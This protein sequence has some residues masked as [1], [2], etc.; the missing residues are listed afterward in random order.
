MNAKLSE[1]VEKFYCYQFLSCSIGISKP[2]G[3]YPFLF[4][5]YMKYLVLRSFRIFYSG[6]REDTIF[7]N[8]IILLPVLTKL[9]PENIFI[10]FMNWNRI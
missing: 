6:I 4:I 5:K 3:W 10:I 2:P 8:I 7:Q 9:E 1:K